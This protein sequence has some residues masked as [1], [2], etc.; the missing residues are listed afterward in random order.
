MPKK[1]SSGKTYTSKGERPN[2]SAQIRKDMRK[3]RTVAEEYV[4]KVQ[5]WRKKKNVVLTVPNPD[6]NNTKARF[7]KVKA[8][9][10][11][12]NPE[13]GKK[14]QNAPQAPVSVEV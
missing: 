2:V 13:P 7:I 3:S 10:E 8:R 12:G 9:H 6:S 1:K 11:W 5:A 14:S 4:A